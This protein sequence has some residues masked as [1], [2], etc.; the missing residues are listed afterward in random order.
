[1]GCDFLLL[2]LLQDPPPPATGYY[3][4]NLGR[5]NSWQKSVIQKASFLPNPSFCSYCIIRII[6]A[7]N[8]PHFWGLPRPLQRLSPILS[9]PCRPR[10]RL[11]FQPTAV[12][13]L[14]LQRGLCLHSPQ[15]TTPLSQCSSGE[16]DFLSP[17]LPLKTSLTCLLWA[18]RVPRGLH[19]TLSW[20]APSWGRATAQTSEATTPAPPCHLQAVGRR[21]VYFGFD[22]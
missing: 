5:G 22:E 4:P 16:P 3:P 15:G 9:F 12:S 11:E 1:M 17:C 7:P 20:G 14:R 10:V 8:A 2:T 6:R 13:V 19:Y 18:Q 21:S